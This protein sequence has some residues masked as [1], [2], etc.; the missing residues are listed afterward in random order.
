MKNQTN[1]IIKIKKINLLKLI[2]LLILTMCVIIY[3]GNYW[4]ILKKSDFKK[5]IATIDDI[6]IEKINTIKPSKVIFGKINY[7]NKFLYRLKVCYYYYFD[8]FDTADNVETNLN[9]TKTY[10]YFY[11]DGIGSEYLEYE[12][13]KEHWNNQ[14]KTKKIKIYYLD[15]YKSISGINKLGVRTKYNNLHLNFYNSISVVIL[16]IIII[17]TICI[18]TSD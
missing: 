16:C 17:L 14:K 11:N 9:D 8:N 4:Y 2:Q 6:L 3:I 5:T 13:I 15:N 12:K 10:G 7:D 18:I 1:M